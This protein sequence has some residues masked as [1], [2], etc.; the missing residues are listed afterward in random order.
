MRVRGTIT[1]LGAA[2]AVSAPLV[3]GGCGLP[4]AIAERPTARPTPTPA[5]AAVA[6]V[7]TCPAAGAQSSA[8]FGH[9]ITATRPYTVAID[10][11]DG[12][13]Y[14]N[15]DQYLDAVFAHAYR[16]PGSF[17]VT[18]TLTDA[19]GRKVTSSCVYSWTAPA[20]GPA[21]AT[22]APTTKQASTTRQPGPFV[23]PG[24]PCPL[25]GTAGVTADGTVMACTIT[26]TDPELRW[27]PS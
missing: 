6:L 1:A 12:N 4:A 22:V 19:T 14:T 16:A 25:E 23:H 21:P 7:L 15:D 8:D 3:L 2:L 18:A 5:A 13:R 20:A 26:A 9:Q 11:G 10:Y 24:T 27:R 17:T